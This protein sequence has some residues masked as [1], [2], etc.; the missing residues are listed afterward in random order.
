MDEETTPEAR[1]GRRGRPPKGEA[2]DTRGRILEAA[3]GSFAREGYAGTSIRKIAREVGVTEGAI[4]A[5]FEGKRAIYETLVAKAGPP[6]ILKELAGGN[7]P[8]GADPESFIRRLVSR[9]IEEWDNPRARLFTSVFLRESG[10]GSDVGGTGILGAVGEVQQR[11][12]SVF[13]RWTE[14][15]LVESESTPEHLVWELFAPIVYIRFVYLHGQATEEERHTGRRLA[16]KHVDH[17]VSAVLS[18]PRGEGS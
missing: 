7:F 4:Y 10:T 1:K 2:G 15:G 8:I 18:K 3:L 9:V 17:F 16:E 11:L 5:H 6:V 14:E 13:R 12:G